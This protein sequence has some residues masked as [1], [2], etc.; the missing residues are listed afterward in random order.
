MQHRVITIKSLV[1]EHKLECWIDDQFVSFDQD[2]LF[3]AQQMTQNPDF[4]F[5]QQ[6][7]PVHKDHHPARP[8]LEYLKT[9][10]A[11]K[12]MIVPEMKLRQAILRSF[13]TLVLQH[14]GHG[15]GRK[16]GRRDHVREKEEESEDEEEGESDDASST[17]A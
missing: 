10:F 16:N 13:A 5:L 4:D 2:P 14:R 8:V 12:R 7:Q 9:E 3:I 15:R 6:Q 1:E 11:K 17:S